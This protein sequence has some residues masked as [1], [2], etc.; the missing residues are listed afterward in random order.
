MRVRKERIEKEE[1]MFRHNQRFVGGFGWIGRVG[2]VVFLGF[3]PGSQAFSDVYVSNAGSAAVSVIDD[4]IN[5]VVATIPVGNE[6]RNLAANALGTRVYVP[7][8]NSD[9]VSVIDTSTR[10]VIAT[11]THADFYEPYAAAVTPDGTEVWI[12]NKQG[13]GSTTGSVTIFSAATNTV[14]STINDPCFSSP[15]GIVMNPVNARAYV[16]NRGNDTVC[17]VDTVSKAV[18]ASVNVGA[19]PRYAVVTPDGASVYVSGS[20][21]F[22]I[23]AATLVPSSIPGVSYG[24]N[25]AL[26]NDGS[27][28]Y[29]AL[30]SSSIAIVDTATNSTSTLTFAGASSTYGVAVVPGTSLGYVTDENSGEVEV[31]DTTTDTEIT[32]VGIPIAVGRTPKAIVAVAT[33]PA[34]EPIPTLS[35]VMLVLLTGMLAL[36]GFRRLR[37]V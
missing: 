15:E 3:L 9:S 10:S 35:V 36:L 4:T 34:P 16:V 22:K 13:G 33:R 24:R 27:K 25:I 21:L 32:G 17:V 29:V 37:L 7:N 5:A 31:F 20:S 28:L 26:S 30:Q 19:E 2:L 12:A 1:D 23:D 6:P 18:L 8:R 11:V 14:S